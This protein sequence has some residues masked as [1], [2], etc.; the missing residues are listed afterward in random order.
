[1]GPRGSEGS[2]VYV[3]ARTALA[4][5]FV[6]SFLSY[7]D[8]FSRAKTDEQVTSEMA[9]RRAFRAFKAKYNGVFL[10]RGDSI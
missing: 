3:P 7:N 1:M 8:R 2:G 4:V 5:L 6:D 10:A 9:P